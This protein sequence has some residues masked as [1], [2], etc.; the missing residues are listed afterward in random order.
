M[1][2]TRAGV[3]PVVPGDEAAQRGLDRGALARRAT[4]GVRN[5]IRS[6]TAST[7]SIRSASSRRPRGRSPLATRSAS[8]CTTLPKPWPGWSGH[9]PAGLALEEPLGRAGQ[10]R[11]PARSPR[12]SPARSAGRGPAARSGSAPGCPTRSP[13]RRP[14][15]P[16]G[17]ATVGRRPASRAAGGPRPRAAARAWRR[18]R[19][20]VRRSS[21]TSPASDSGAPAAGRLAVRPGSTVAPSSSTNRD[22]CSPSSSGEPTAVTTQPLR[23][24]GCRRRRTA[25]APRRAARTRGAA[26]SSPSAP[27]RSA[28]SSDV[29]AAQVGPAVLLDVGD[30]DE[31]PLQALGAVR[32]EQPDGVAAHAALGEGVGRDLL[33]APAW[34]GSRATLVWPRCSSARAATSNSAHDRV[35]VAVR[36]PGGL[37]PGLDA[38]AQPA[39]PVGAVPQQPEHL[40]GGGAASARGRAPC[41][42]PGQRRRPAAAPGRAAPSSS[43]G[44]SSASREQLAADAAAASGRR[45]RFSRA[46]SAGPGRARRWRRGRRAGEV[47]SASARSAPR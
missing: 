1:A 10:Q 40:L 31:P 3:G 46:R 32:G 12:R 47:S 22:G 7:C 16:G 6:Q 2:S 36:Q 27:I 23:G 28:C 9:A 39:P 34:P 24:P 41:E 30:D 18:G 8:A 19:R 26:G 44:R 17:R 43:P 21:A 42:Q 25:G 11:R 20:A 15:R 38:A 37:P 13:G 5:S 14:R 29:A 4:T 35:E 45:P 33:G